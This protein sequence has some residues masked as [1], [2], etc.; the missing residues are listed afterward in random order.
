MPGRV[1]GRPEPSAI[2]IPAGNPTTFDIAV[3]PGTVLVG[4]PHQMA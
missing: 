4:D 1:F 3:G 2:D